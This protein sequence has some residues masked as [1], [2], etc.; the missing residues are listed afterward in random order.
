MGTKDRE[1]AGGAG[2]PLVSGEAGVEGGDEEPHAAPR[3]RRG[4]SSTSSSATISV[5]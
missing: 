1:E 5:E 3:D 4:H 2:N